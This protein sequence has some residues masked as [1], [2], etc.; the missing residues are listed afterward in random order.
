APA[1]CRRRRP[2]WAEPAAGAALQRTETQPDFERTSSPSWLSSAGGTVT[3]NWMYA[4]PPL[5]RPWAFS[6]PLLP[7]STL[8]SVNTAVWSWPSQVIGLRWL[9]SHVLAT[10]LEPSLASTGDR[11]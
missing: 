7:G 1:R 10:L 5:W 11:L 4:L 6:R 9:C 8:S 3:Q 2:A